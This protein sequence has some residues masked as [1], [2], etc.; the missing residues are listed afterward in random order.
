MSRA[1]CVH[2]GQEL[3]GEPGGRRVY[4]PCQAHCQGSGA[5]GLTARVLPLAAVAAGV[6]KRSAL[7]ANTGLK[8]GEPFHVLFL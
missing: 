7:S 2:G 5:A 3:P 6:A 1:L 8:R 4:P